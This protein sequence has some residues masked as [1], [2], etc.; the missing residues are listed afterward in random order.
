MPEFMPGLELSRRFYWEAIRPLLDQYYPHLPHAA[1][2]LGPGSEVLG[3]DTAM[4]MDHD[5]YPNVLIFLQDRDEGLKD[6]LKEMLRQNL[7]HDFLGFGVDSAPVEEG[8][9]TRMMVVRADG[10]VEH[11]VSLVT[12]R[13]FVLKWMNWN[14]DEPLDG[15][16]WL[17]IPSQTLLMMTA[18]AVHYDGVGELTACRQRL[19]WYPPETWL[20]LLAAGWR[21][22]SQEEPLMARAGYVGDELGSAIMASRLVRDVMSLCF[23]MEKQYAPYPKWFGSAFLKLKCA[24][25]LRPVL[26]R[27][28]QAATWQRREAALIEA[29]TY[30]AKWHNHLR[31]TEPVP[32]ASTSFFGRPFQIIQSDLFIKALLEKITDPALRRIADKGLIGSIDQFSDSTDLRS[33]PGWRLNLHKLYEIL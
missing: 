7:P 11:N 9:G 2:M 12:L 5:W 21:R 23:L 32:E 10:P 4:S 18:G 6:P 14:I 24:A 28:Q 20:F 29:Y 13:S 17:T 16:D 25:I 22:I 3:F 8:S 30:L 27:A 26:W 1:A 19:A 15:V 33:N 31:L